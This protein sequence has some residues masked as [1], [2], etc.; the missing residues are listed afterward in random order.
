LVTA[1]PCWPWL[2]PADQVADPYD[3]A[4]RLTANGE[5]MQ[6]SNTGQMIFRAEDMIEYPSAYLPLQPGDIIATG[7][8]AGT[9]AGQ[10]RFLRPGDVMV[11]EIEGIGRLRNRVAVSFRSGARDG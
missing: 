5:V 2:V 1:C 3:L 9:G 11:A 8:C 7:T 10:G 6:D 4:L